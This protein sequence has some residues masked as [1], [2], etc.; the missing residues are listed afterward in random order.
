MDEAED[1]G[2]ER[3]VAT[4]DEWLTDA[5]ETQHGRLYGLARL[6]L[7]SDLGAEDVVQEA[8]LRVHASGKVP[9]NVPAYLRTTVVN[10]CRSR[11]SRLGRERRR[12]DPP[13][14][15]I[16][17]PEIDETWS[18]IRRLPA[19]QRAVIVL[20]FYEDLPEAEI[21]SLLGC[22]QGTVKSSLHRA[23]AQLRKELAGD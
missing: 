9:G 17:N 14:L 1:G 16:S 2:S 4:D 11:Q 10:L 12:V 20:R 23:L 6:L 19:R 3:V 13:R 22:A 15:A 21:A 7:G 8:F 18:V 5:Y